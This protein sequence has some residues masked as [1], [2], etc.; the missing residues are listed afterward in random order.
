LGPAIRRAVGKWGFDIILDGEVLS[1]DSQREET[2]PF[3]S[4]RTIANVRRAWMERN[5][6]IDPRDRDIQHDH[7]TKTMNGTQSRIDLDDDVFES[8]GQECWLQFLVFDVTFVDGPGAANFLSAVVSP[9]FLPITS[10][11][12]VHLD[13]FE[14]KKILHRLIDSQKREVEIVD[15][16]I[17][18]P[19]GQMVLGN[20]YFD[21]R[22]PVFDEGFPAYAIDSLRCLLSGAVPQL[23]EK[24]VERRMEMSDEDISQ[25]RAWKVDH[26]YKTLVEEQRL[27]GLVFK[28]LSAPYFLGVE[29]RS[30][31]YWHKFKP[32]YFNGAAASDLDVIIIGAYFATGFRNKGEPASFL[33]ACLDSKDQEK[34]FPL[35]KVNGGS[36]DKATRSLLFQATGFKRTDDN[37]DIKD[38]GLRLGK[39]F[40][41]DTVPDFVSCTRGEWRC[42]KKDFPDLWIHPSDSVVL[43]LNAGE[44]VS[45]DT[46]PV[47]LT[48]R[49]PRISK[50]RIGADRKDPLEVEDDNDLLQIFRDVENCRSS[51]TEARNVTLSPL[52]S[53]KRD[54]C[55]FLT[56]KQFAQAKKSKKQ[57][58]V[59]RKRAVEVPR[60]V[61][62]AVTTALHGFRFT[63]LN[64]TYRIDR[65]SVE[66]DEAKQQG[67]LEAA[68]LVK[69]ADDVRKYIQEHGGVLRITADGG[70]CL[71]VGGK[72][73]DPMVKAH[74][75][76]IE[77]AQAELLKQRFK[78]EE[79]T[80]KAEKLKEISAEKGVLRW[81]FVFSLV[82]QYLE[83]NPGG[84]SI[85]NISSTP[86]KPS[87]LDY[88]ARP[89]K[90]SS[91]DVD[92]E[93]FD[94][95]LNG[96]Q[97]MQKALEIIKKTNKRKQPLSW[98]EE[99][100][101]R[102]EPDERWICGCSSEPLWPYKRDHD[103]MHVVIVFP[104]VFSDGLGIP[105]PHHISNESDQSRWRKLSNGAQANRLLAMLPLL[106]STG[107]FVTPHLHSDVTHILCDLR[108]G[109]EEVQILGSAESID[110]N[111]FVDASRGKEI[112][113]RINVFST[114]KD[115]V[116]PILLVSPRWVCKVFNQ[117]R[118]RNACKDLSL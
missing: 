95:D 54:V 78:R 52:L 20:D 81:T 87:I 51:N 44:I 36:T 22:S 2:V 31:H 113:T 76:T 11:S 43:T 50:V 82:H 16:W 30:T 63:V 74:I 10:G 25:R 8:A 18:R 19:T 55:R 48:L 29:S 100:M 9:C 37:N 59:N 92:P 49:F 67:W 66:N 24:D 80:T 14:R 65:N 88:L 90:E 115:F 114:H 106:L 34:Y 73:D 85:D 53:R 21:S 103:V 94:V 108:D 61:V 86:A 42:P 35:V 17:I 101:E 6:L 5:G 96:A 15:T 1:W 93:I 47:G 112:A 39:W 60:D 40:R 107:A 91:M 104:D 99:C 13:L 71:I 70:S 57:K 26:L 98:R 89:R 111:I 69:T 117:D 105:W 28:D 32:D 68:L 118:E 46:F 83:K 72:E 45:S 23:R 12:L 84:R 109:A 4:N 75:Q 110:P 7:N 27:E 33:C 64:G 116:T 41:Q 62:K 3:G 58:I 77:N 56:E 102:L 38:D 97:A 79:S